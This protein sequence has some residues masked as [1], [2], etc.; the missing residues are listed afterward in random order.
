MTVAGGKAGQTGDSPGEGQV[1]QQ[2]G[3]RPLPLRS[4]THWFRLTPVCL[5]LLQLS[6]VSLAGF[7][8]VALAVSGS[9]S[10]CVSECPWQC[11]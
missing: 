8:T 9:V 4:P 11:F 7:L 6:A 5:L 2:A 3:R 1:Q 10:D